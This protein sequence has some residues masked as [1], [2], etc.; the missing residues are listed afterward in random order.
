MYPITFTGVSPRSLGD[1]LKG[2]GLIA[3]IGE[4]CPDALFWWDDSSRLVVEGA[5]NEDVV[6]S[7]KRLADW[8]KTVGNSFRPRRGEQCG[9]PLPCRYH[10]WAGRKGKKVTCQES[11]LLLRSSAYLDELDGEL[12]CVARAVAVPADSGKRTEPNDALFP[13]HGQQGSGDY[14]AQLARAADAAGTTIEDDLQWSLFGRGPGITRS[15]GSGYLFFPE[16]IK[17]YAT[18]V[19]KWN[20]EK[21]APVG[22]WCF[23]LALRG[24]LLLRGA[25]RRPRWR[26]TGYPA[27]PFVFDG[28]GVA[29]IH[30]PTWCGDFPRTLNELLR[31]VNQ[32]HVPLGHRSYAVTAAEFR[33]AVQARG[34]AVGFEAFHRFVLEARKPGQGERKK[35]SQA[36]PRGLTRVRGSR[37]AVQFRHMITPL[38]ESGWIDQFLL[39]ARRDNE[40]ERGYAIER[41]RRVL[42]TTIH[43]AIDEPVDDAYVA[44][45]EAVWH[46]NRDLLL[47]GKLRSAFEKSDK[48]A[49]PAP[50]LPADVWE[51]AFSDRLASSSEWRLARALGSILGVSGDGDQKVGPI[52]E[53][54]LPVQWNG[55]TWALPTEPNPLSSVWSGRLPLRDF[56]SLL[57]RR[58][59]VSEGLPRLPFAG[60][61][62]APLDDVLRLI[63]NE[64]DMSEVHRLVP[65]FG[66][67]DWPNAESAEV[68]FSTSIKVRLP[69]PASY[70]ALRLWFELGI[71]PDPKAR[72]PRDGEIPRALSLGGVPHVERAIGRALARLRIQGLPWRREEPAPTGKAVA[73]LSPQV[74][75]EE[76]ERMALAVMVPISHADTLA[77][78]RRL[79]VATI[80]KET[81]A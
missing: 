1:L 64:V 37:D 75:R 7:C 4:Q 14:F 53:Q 40:K 21:D 32:F 34:P 61:R 17:R 25:L 44:V 8:A 22:P 74:T 57:W 45:L 52:L 26:R 72:P 24:A 47:A 51:R 50:P 66:L 43:R 58:W 60:R 38:G 80:E 12:A 11:S 65:L 16:A 18:G 39:P 13:A 78:S 10:G 30:L 63:R 67:L 69:I 2:Y 19:K 5:S 29:E 15:V 20:R 73:T 3:V 81:S 36:I 49:R 46:L 41:R 62:T 54:L 23:L 59:L 55:N 6:R 70:A 33:V 76:A 28:G 31:Q 56:Q 9:E 68:R 35:A 71:R 77:L 79:W 27:F 42:D 48:K